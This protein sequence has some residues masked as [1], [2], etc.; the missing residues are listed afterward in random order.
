VGVGLG[1][2]R[3]RIP[4]GSGCLLGMTAEQVFNQ[5]RQLM[6]DSSCWLIQRCDQSKEI[7]AN[8]VYTQAD[9][10]GDEKILA[11]RSQ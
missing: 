5:L 8:V 2:S 7:I 11:S 4:A 1:L 9:R 3:R 10:V 6:T